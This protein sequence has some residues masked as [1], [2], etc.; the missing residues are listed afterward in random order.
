MPLRHTVYCKRD[1][2]VVTP[3]ALFKHMDLLDFRTLGE[4]YGVSDEVV[5]AALPPRI[6]NIDREGF[7]RYRLT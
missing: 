1:I 5:S 3:D 2:G 4:D 6:T 7:R